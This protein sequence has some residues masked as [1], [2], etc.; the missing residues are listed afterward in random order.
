MLKPFTVC[1]SLQSICETVV[2]SRRFVGAKEQ[3][4]STYSRILPLFER[5]KYG[6]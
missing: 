4:S 1:G 6:L 2:D 5:E 3:K